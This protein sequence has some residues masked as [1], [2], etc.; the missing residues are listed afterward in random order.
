MV[1]DYGKTIPRAE[2]RLNF[3]TFVEERPRENLDQEIGPIVAR[4]LASCVICDD[5]I[6]GHNGG[7][8]LELI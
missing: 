6:L 8:M 2:F 1:L 7:F 4:T 3:L 5:V